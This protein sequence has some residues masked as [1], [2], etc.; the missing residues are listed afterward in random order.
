MTDYDSVWSAIALESRAAS[1]PFRSTCESRRFGSWRPRQPATGCWRRN[2]P[3]AS[4][5]SKARSRGVR[6][7]NWLSPTQ[8]Q[9]LL[10]APAITTTK[11][12]R[13]RAVLAVLL[14]CGSAPVRSGGA[15]DGAHYSS[16]TAAG[17][18]W[19]SSGSTGAC[20]PFRCQP[21]S[22]WRLT[23]GSAP[24]AWRTSTSS[25]PSTGATKSPSRSCPRKLCGR[26]VA[27]AAFAFIVDFAKV[28]LFNRLKI[29]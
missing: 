26:L 10:N 27:A 29:A 8:A 1:V 5:V 16:G 18:L 17:A 7:G 11:G 2:W 23:R 22:R 20:V 6:T 25:G 24:P 12:L 28:P 13:D 9:A 21:G 4:P 3:P 19:T 15:Y 14:G